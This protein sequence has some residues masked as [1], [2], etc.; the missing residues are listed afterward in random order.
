MNQATLFQTEECRLPGYPAKWSPCKAYR[1]TLWRTWTDDPMPPYVAFV[2]LNP[3]TA[4]EQNDD[5]TIRRCIGFATS[6]GFNAMCML[7]LFAFR[8]TDPREMKGADDPLGE[9]ADFWTVNICAG[10]DRVVAAWGCDGGF[11]KR[12]VEVRLLLSVMEKPLHVLKFNKDGSPMHPLFCPSSVEPITW[13][14]E[15]VA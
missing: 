15:A 5:P 14:R 10:A 9:D 13:E 4:D 1:Y 8:A 2:G 6:W 11:N 12:D 7:N 3:S